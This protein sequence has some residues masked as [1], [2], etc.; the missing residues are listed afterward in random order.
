MVV[1]EHFTVINAF[2]LTASLLRRHLI[3]PTVQMGSLKLRSTA[4]QKSNW[5]RWEGNTSPRGESLGDQGIFSGVR[6]FLWDP[7][8]MPKVLDHSWF[9]GTELLP[10][11]AN[12]A[13]L[14]LLLLSEDT[15]E[16]LVKSPL[17]QCCD[18]SQLKSILPKW[19]KL[20]RTKKCASAALETVP[21]FLY[22]LYSYLPLRKEFICSPPSLRRRG[23]GFS[24]MYCMYLSVTC[25][26]IITKS[27]INLSQIGLLSNLNQ[28]NAF[29][30]PTQKAAL[31]SDFTSMCTKAHIHSSCRAL[32]MPFCHR[33]DEVGSCISLLPP[34]SL[35]SGLFPQH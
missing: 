19:G 23:I 8:W 7:T 6:K 30:S 11:S 2:T 16:K 33:W 24:K 3:S 31:F 20:I 12:P 14:W 4:P 22:P 32:V 18:S 13:E 21:H 9:P 5:N 26:L 27:M 1:A 15:V 29:L 34:E 35:C 17:A 10:A 28:A 25:L